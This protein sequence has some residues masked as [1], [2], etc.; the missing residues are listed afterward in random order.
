VCDGGAAVPGLDDDLAEADQ[1]P[2]VLG[3]HQPLAEVLVRYGIGLGPRRV[4]GFLIEPEAVRTGA[5]PVD[6]VGPERGVDARDAPSIPRLVARS[7]GR[8]S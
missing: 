5:H 3:D 4:G 6:A 1:L 2:V 8:H 7:D